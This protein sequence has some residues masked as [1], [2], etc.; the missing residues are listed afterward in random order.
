MAAVRRKFEPIGCVLLLYRMS[1]YSNLFNSAWRGWTD[2]THT[3]VED[4]VNITGSKA[5]CYNE[6]LN[7]ITV[8]KKQELALKGGKPFCEPSTYYGSY[9]EAF[10]HDSPVGAASRYASTIFSKFSRYRAHICT[11]IRLIPEERDEYQLGIWRISHPQPL[12]KGQ[13]DLWV[14]INEVTASEPWAWPMMIGL[15]E[16]YYTKD[17]IHSVPVVLQVQ[18]K[19]MGLGYTEENFLETQ[20]ELWKMLQWDQAKGM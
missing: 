5:T 2:S 14:S 8:L 4:K 16:M 7:E 1:N 10:Q 9:L 6:L 11:D 20:K 3:S 15:Y 17:Y 13:H 19:F 12:T 18:E